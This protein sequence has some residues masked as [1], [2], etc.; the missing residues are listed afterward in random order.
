MMGLDLMGLSVS[1]GPACSSGKVGPS[2]VLDAMG[3]PADLAGCALRLSLGWST[4][5]DDIE[6]YLKGFG[7]VVTRQLSRRGR[8]A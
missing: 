8:A 1:A 3:V 4:T 5:K 7:E 2:H 6:T